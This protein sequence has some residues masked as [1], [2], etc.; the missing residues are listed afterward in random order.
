MLRAF[1]CSPYTADTEEKIKENENR[2]EELCKMLS[3]WGFAPFAPHLLYTRF[4]RDSNPGE[5]ELGMQCGLNWLDVA[6]VIFVDD[7]SGIS[8]G[9]KREITYAKENKIKIMY[10]S[11]HFGVLK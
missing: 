7:L 3:K 1:I 5:R 11:D 10:M 9:M 4:W 2:A 8:K 6:D